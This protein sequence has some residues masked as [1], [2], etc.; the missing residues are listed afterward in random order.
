M[1]EIIRY[2]KSGG[3]VILAHIQNVY[4]YSWSGIIHKIEK[5]DMGEKFGNGK[6]INGEKK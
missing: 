5:N 6:L 4:L 3:I 1:H 2:R